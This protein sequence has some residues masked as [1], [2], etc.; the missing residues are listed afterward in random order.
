[1]HGSIV[2]Y[3]DCL[4]GYRCRKFLENINYLL[5]IG[6]SFYHSGVQAAVFRHDSENARRR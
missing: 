6:S 3:N 1:M 4:F 5:R 2:C